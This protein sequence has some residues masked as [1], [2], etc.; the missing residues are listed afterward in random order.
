MSLH[1]LHMC[2]PGELDFCLGFLTG[3]GR[4]GLID[5]STFIVPLAD[6]SGRITGGVVFGLEALSWSWT[7]IR[8]GVCGI[9]PGFD[10]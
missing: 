9:S 3:R 7:S 2:D 1:G 4:L 6:C 8:D 10:L 5:S